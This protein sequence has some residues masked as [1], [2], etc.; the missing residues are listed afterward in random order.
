MLSSVLSSKTAIQV[1]IHIMR[2]FTKMREFALTYG[3]IIKQLSEIEKTIKIDQQQMN[4]NTERIDDAFALLTEIL[5]DTK[6][7]NKNLIGFRPK[8]EEVSKVISFK[9]INL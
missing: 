2:T 6:R 8:S 7:T 9:E 3:D 1:N 5:N 4:Y